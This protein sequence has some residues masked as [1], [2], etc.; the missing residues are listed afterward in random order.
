MVDKKESKFE[1]SFTFY[2]ASLW[3]AIHF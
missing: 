3:Q 2:L 1:D